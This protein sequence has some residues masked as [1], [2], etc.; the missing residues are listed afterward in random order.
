[1]IA[2][3]REREMNALKG[4]VARWLLPKPLPAFGVA[5]GVGKANPLTELGIEVRPFFS[6]SSSPH[7]R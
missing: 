4:Q 3:Q 5:V 1:M 6:L 2:L 7:A